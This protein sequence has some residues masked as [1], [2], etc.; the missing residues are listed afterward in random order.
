MLIIS[1]FAL[2]LLY[3]LL[4]LETSTASILV[5]SL[6]IGVASGVL[7]NP[8]YSELS[9]RVSGDVRSTVI[10]AFDLTV[11]LCMATTV[12]VMGPIAASIGSRI[13]VLA[14][15]ILSISLAIASIAI[16]YRERY[17]G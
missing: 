10:N 14:A 1:A 3:L 7:L 9:K 5:A 13:S 2:S 6:L 16:H 11:N 17:H 15:S 12:L 8:V 4:F